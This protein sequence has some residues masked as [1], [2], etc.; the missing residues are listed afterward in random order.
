MSEKDWADKAAETIAENVKTVTGQEMWIGWI[1]QIADII[2]SAAPSSA[3][4][5][6]A[7]KAHD[8]LEEVTGDCVMRCAE[9]CFECGVRAGTKHEPHCKS[10]FAVITLR[11]ALEGQGRVCWWVRP[12]GMTMDTYPNATF[13]TACGVRMPQSMLDRGFKF[14][15]YCGGEI[16]LKENG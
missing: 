4:V 2:R 5:E 3:L 1:P 7:K 8:A 9:K 11:A 12:F 6:A 10:G 14:C 16:K 13:H 15:P